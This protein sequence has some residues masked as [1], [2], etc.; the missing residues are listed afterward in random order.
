MH[1]R[2]LTGSSYPRFKKKHTR[3]KS[4]DSNKI[5]DHTLR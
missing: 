3:L 2:T 4:V 5:H 1:F